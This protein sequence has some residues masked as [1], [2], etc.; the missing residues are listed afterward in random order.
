MSQ[1]SWVAFWLSF[2][3]IH[4]SLWIVHDPVEHISSTVILFMVRYFIPSPYEMPTAAF[5]V[6]FALLLPPSSRGLTK[7]SFVSCAVV[8]FNCH[9]NSDGV[10]L[11]GILISQLLCTRGL[12]WDHPSD[13]N[14]C[15]KHCQIPVLRVG[16]AIVDRVCW[17]FTPPNMALEWR[18]GWL[19]AGAWFLS[20]YAVLFA[21]APFMP[22]VWYLLWAGIVVGLGFAF[23]PDQSPWWFYLWDVTIL[24]LRGLLFVSYIL[25]YLN[26]MTADLFPFYYF[27]HKWRMCS[28]RWFP[29]SSR[30]LDSLNNA[31]LCEQCGSFTAESK[32]LMGSSS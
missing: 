1:N 28:P 16:N 22:V 25:Y 4:P 14:Y 32:L 20:F 29:I 3:L 19:W 13:H 18:L 21:L 10:H 30:N 26:T 24:V 12:L 31:A 23:R 27:S 9:L 5:W 15:K 2:L 7:G 6:L 8:I 17:P 11:P